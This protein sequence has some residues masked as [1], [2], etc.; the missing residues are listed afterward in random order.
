MQLYNATAS[1]NA[2]IQY[3]AGI[4]AAHPLPLTKNELRA[5]SGKFIDVK[6]GY[7]IN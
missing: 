5:L 1:D 4:V 6:I 3:P 7:R 2:P